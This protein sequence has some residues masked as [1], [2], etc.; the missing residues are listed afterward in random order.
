MGPL[1]CCRALGSG[2]IGLPLSSGHSV[3]QDIGFI[4]AS[5]GET[6]CG[7]GQ[8]HPGPDQ[9]EAGIGRRPESCGEG[10]PW[11]CVAGRPPGRRS[12]TGVS[13]SYRRAPLPK[14]QQW[15]QRRLCGRRGPGA[16]C[17]AGDKAAGAHPPRGSPSLASGH[18]WPAG[19]F[20]DMLESEVLR[21]EARPWDPPGLLRRV[22][23]ASSACHLLGAKGLGEGYSPAEAKYVALLA[24]AHPPTCGAAPNPAAGQPR[25]RTDMMAWH[26]WFY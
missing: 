10:L 20:G 23:R 3:L 17:S 24:E 15:G 14:P 18:S 12:R 5:Q 25:D 26:C 9:R 11:T 1:L 22:I 7:V 6:G 4:P 13:P 16:V 2:F 19:P 21:S 8:A